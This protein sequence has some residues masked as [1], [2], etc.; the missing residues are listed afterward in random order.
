M[1]GKRE[2]V[3]LSAASTSVQQTLQCTWTSGNRV[4]F[5]TQHS[6]QNLPYF[7]HSNTHFRKERKPTPKKPKRKPH[8]P[9]HTAKCCCSLL[10]QPFC[11]APPKMIL[12]SKWPVKEQS[13]PKPKGREDIVTRAFLWTLAVSLWLF[14]KMRVSLLSAQEKNMGNKWCKKGLCEWCECTIFYSNI[15]HVKNYSPQ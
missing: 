4:V 7:M 12:F 14:C 15:T 10:G 13:K 1:G 6:F 8:H 2:E 5:H 9:P 11:S 3:M